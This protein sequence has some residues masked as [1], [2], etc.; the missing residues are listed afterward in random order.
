MVT[1]SKFC[2]L[3]VASVSKIRHLLY[4]AP[5]RL[6]RPALG[7]RDMYIED[8]VIREKMRVIIDRL[9]P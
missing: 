5:C 4:P 7:N 8:A 6:E 2:R 9:I 1:K 3:I